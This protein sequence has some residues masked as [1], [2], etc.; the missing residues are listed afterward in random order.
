M[1]RFTLLCL[2][3]VLPAASALAEWPERPV[4]LV[5]SQPPGS[6]PDILARML[7][8][9]LT[10]KWGQPIVVENKPGGQ[11]IVGAQ[12]AAKA[13]P[14]GYTYYYATTAALVV[15]VYTFKQLPYDPRKDFV[16]VTM[17]GLSPFVLAVNPS[18]PATTLKE[19]MAYAKANPDKIN[20]ATEGTK[21]L[22]GLLTDMIGA[23]GGVK[24]VHVPYNGVQPGILDT[25]AG[26]TLATV[27]SSTALSQHL[28][29]GALRPIAVSFP[30]RVTGLDNVPTIAETWPG[31]EYVGWHGLA[32]P[33]GTPPEAVRRF[34]RDLDALMKEPEV[35]AKL[36]EF[37][38]IPEGG[39]PEAMGEFLRQEHVRWAKLVKDIGAVPE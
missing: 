12:V 16:P 32:A 39:T 26:R 23:T 30:K 24:W 19:L 34:S 27:Q 3:L 10:R 20:V 31:F 15:N 28:K 8:E 22:S 4:R 29:R 17:I 11:N 14:D 9:R 38:V 6:S 1:K 37:G 25:I 2:L 5:L 18:V 33:T 7:G 13:A 21:T 36:L 35:A